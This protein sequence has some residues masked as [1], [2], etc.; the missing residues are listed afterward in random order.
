MGK[1]NRPSSIWLESKDG[2]VEYYFQKAGSIW[3]V[4]IMA[5]VYAVIVAL[6]VLL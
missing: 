6:S 2:L 3:R 1:I 4:A 5:A